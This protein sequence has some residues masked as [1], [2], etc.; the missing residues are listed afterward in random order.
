MSKVV[1]EGYILVS[2]SD[3][4]TVEKELPNHIKLSL[5]EAGCLVFKVS[6]DRKNLNRFSVYEEF[7][8]QNAFTWHQQRVKHSQWGRISADVQ[9]HYKISGLD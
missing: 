4:E 9:R 2:D 3:I 5:Q 1:L 7:V 8:D 6:Q